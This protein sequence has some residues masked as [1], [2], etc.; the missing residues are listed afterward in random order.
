[1]YVCRPLLEELDPN[2]V[3]VLARVQD[4]LPQIEASNAALLQE[5]LSS[6]DIENVEETDGHY[7]EMVRVI[8]H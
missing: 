3:E 7:I 5:D 2:V 1:M 4:F 8:H 6:L